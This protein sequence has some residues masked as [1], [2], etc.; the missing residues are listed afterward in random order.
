MGSHVGLAGFGLPTGLLTC[1]NYAAPCS[2]TRPQGPAGRGCAP[3]APDPAVDGIQHERGLGRIHCRAVGLH[4]GLLDRSSP[5]ARDDPSHQFPGT[6]RIEDP[7][8]QAVPRNT[9]AVRHREVD[10]VQPPG[11]DSK[12]LEDCSHLRQRLR[13]ELL[14]EENVYA[15]AAERVEGG[16]MNTSECWPR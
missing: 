7:F 3:V 15:L 6:G 10:L 8:H 14:E 12:E 4:Q 11:L 13:D 16:D 9:A 1:R 5:G 2:S